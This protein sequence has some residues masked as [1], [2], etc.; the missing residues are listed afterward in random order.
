MSE[1]ETMRQIMLAISGLPG[2]LFYRRNVGVARTQRG[3]VVRFGIPGQADI[4]GIYRGRAVEV[5]VKTDEGR[6]SEA[7]KR[8]KMAV[9]RAGGLFVL[10]RTPADALSA[11]RDLEAGPLPAASPERSERAGDTP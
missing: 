9:E 1:T 2:G 3:E 7:Q 10:A 4:G 5:E 6:L 11:L 8:W